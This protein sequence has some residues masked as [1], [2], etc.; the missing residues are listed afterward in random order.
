M[1]EYMC[2]I[3]TVCLSISLTVVCVEEQILNGEMD[4][5]FVDFVFEDLQ[6]PQQDLDKKR[7]FETNTMGLRF[8]I[9]AAACSF[10]DFN[11]CLAVP[12]QEAKGTAYIRLPSLSNPQSKEILNH[13]DLKYLADHIVKYLRNFH[14]NEI[15]IPV[16]ASP[17]VLTCMEVFPWYSHTCIC[18]CMYNVHTCTNI[19]C[20]VHMLY[21]EYVCMTCCFLNAG[22]RRTSC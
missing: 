10:Q 21:T 7:G 2:C 11:T 8:P 13:P 5:L 1:H 14:S 17:C 15:N 3:F 4:D 22:L 20:I 19:V 18:T 6:K 9:W 12:G 16:S